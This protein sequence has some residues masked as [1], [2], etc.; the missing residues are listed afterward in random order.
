MAKKVDRVSSVEEASA[1]SAIA[2]RKWKTTVN[3]QRSRE[4]SQSA[5]Y[6]D[7]KIAK[8]LQ[9]VKYSLL[10]YPHEQKNPIFF[11]FFE[12]SGKSQSAEK[13]K[14]KAFGIFWTSILLQN[15]KKLKGD[16]WETLKK[17]AKKV[18]Q[19]RNNMHKKF[20]Q[21]RDS[22]PRPSAWQTSKNPN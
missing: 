2:P 10:Q 9:S 18:L 12:V 15:W 19:S 11:N 3:K 6:L 4:R 5:H 22:K 20:V 13:C 16:P 21:G 1:P 7:S 8:G 17:L 14:S